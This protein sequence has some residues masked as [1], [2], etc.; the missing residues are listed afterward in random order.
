MQELKTALELNSPVNY[1]QS[2]DRRG[3]SKSITLSIGAAG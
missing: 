3:T 2:A 1:A